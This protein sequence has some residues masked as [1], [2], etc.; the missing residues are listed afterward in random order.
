MARKLRP[1]SGSGYLGVTPPI[2]TSGPSRMEET[3]T[4]ELEQELRSQGT[5]E[6]EEESK[7]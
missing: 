6:S 3:M 1:S 5:F 2:A 4:E 7:R